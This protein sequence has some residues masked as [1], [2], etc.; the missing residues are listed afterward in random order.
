VNQLSNRWSYENKL[1]LFVIVTEFCLTSGH[2]YRTQADIWG[3]DSKDCLL[4]RGKRLG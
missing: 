1:C 2:K 3:T 4:R